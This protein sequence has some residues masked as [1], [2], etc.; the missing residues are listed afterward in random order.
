[1]PEPTVIL[2]CGPAGLFAA[3]AI[4]QSGGQPLI[5]STKVKSEFPGAQYLQQPIPGLTSEKPDGEIHT[6]LYGSKESYA[7][8]VYGDPEIATSWPMYS[9]EQDPAWDL[10]AAYD[11]A[12]ELYSDIVIDSEI[13]PSDIDEF[14]ASFPVVIST[15]PAWALCGHLRGND[16]HKFDQM[17]INVTSASVMPHDD[18]NYVVYNGTDQGGWYRCARVFGVESTEAIPSKLS[19]EE[20]TAVE[21][22]A[23]Y[24]ILGNNCNCHPNLVRAGRLGTWQ[25]GVLTHH[26]FGTALAAYMERLAA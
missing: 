23:G 2:G 11:R 17:Q 22:R 21:W 14:T 20:R 26:A 25:R 18:E 7:N 12:W 19:A 4:V 10:R 5:F 13:S 3:H 16:R 15:I 6:Y 24:K 8:R 1:M 9:H